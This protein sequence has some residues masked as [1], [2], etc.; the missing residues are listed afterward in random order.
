[1]VNLLEASLQAIIVELAIGRWPKAIPQP[2]NQVFVAMLRGAIEGLFCLG[3]PCR[4]THNCAS[5]ARRRRLQRAVGCPWSWE[6][7]EE[8]VACI[9]FRVVWGQCA[10]VA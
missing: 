9:A 6:I 5:I 10:I 8:G 1:M 2:L 3:N 4:R 7:S